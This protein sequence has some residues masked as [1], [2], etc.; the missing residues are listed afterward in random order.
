MTDGSFRPHEKTVFDEQIESTSVGWGHLV[1]RGRVE[2]PGVGTVSLQGSGSLESDRHNHLSL[3]G[4]SERRKAFLLTVWGWEHV[5]QKGLES[6]S[7]VWLC[8]SRTHVSQTA[9]LLSTASLR[10]SDF[11]LHH[12]PPPPAFPFIDHVTSGEVFLPRSQFVPLKREHICGLWSHNHPQWVLAVG[13]SCPGKFSWHR[14]RVLTV[15]LKSRKH[16]YSHCGPLV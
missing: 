13:G 7:C 9:H 12:H 1:P 5:H 2:N 16:C 15:C 6:C 11:E 14:N 10:L 3:L 8:R 4:S